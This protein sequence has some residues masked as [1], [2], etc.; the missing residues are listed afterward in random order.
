MKILALVTIRG[1]KRRDARPDANSPSLKCRRVSFAR[2]SVARI[3]RLFIPHYYSTLCVPSIPPRG[4][5]KQLHELRFVA[6]RACNSLK[7]AAD[8]S[9][10]NFIRADGPNIRLPRHMGRVSARMSSPLRRSRDQSSAQ[11]LNAPVS[12]F[13][14]NRERSGRSRN[15]EPARDGVIGKFANHTDMHAV[16]RL[17]LRFR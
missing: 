3:S 13:E 2:A 16:E 10:S 11:H 17:G 1:S 9:S 14:I 8:C 15:G 5:R 6:A 4:I 12:F 7:S